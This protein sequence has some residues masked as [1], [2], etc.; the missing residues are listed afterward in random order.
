V[1]TVVGVPP[2]IAAPEP[3]DRSA[4]EPVSEDEA[5]GSLAALARDL[6]D[7]RDRLGEAQTRYDAARDAFVNH[8]VIRS[9]TETGGLAA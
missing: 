9:I 2:A 7:A 8:H 1:K 3:D 6:E 5:A 4:P